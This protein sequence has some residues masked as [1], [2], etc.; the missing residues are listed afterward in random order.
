MFRQARPS[1]RVIRRLLAGIGV[2][3]LTG[4]LVAV[5][6]A[7][8]AAADEH[9]HVTITGVELAEELAITAQEQP[10]QY[11]ALHRELA[12]L[13]SRDGDAPEPDPDTLGPQYTLVLHT[14]ERSHRFHAFP[15]A[16]GG[17]RVFRPAEQPDDRTVDEGWFFGRL[18]LPETLREIGVPLTGEQ[19]GGGGSRITPEQSNPPESEALGFLREWQEGMLLTV[20][21]AVAV[22]AGVA[23]I[24]FLLHRER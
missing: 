17:P 7:A 15:L 16:Q 13:T 14:G 9:Q 12:W 18:S 22:L 8:P 6:P 10:E 5:G 24:A 21:L 23:S 20:G 1:S 19:A 2:A 4:L 11:A 3:A